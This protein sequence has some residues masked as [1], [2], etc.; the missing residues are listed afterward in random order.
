[1]S[2]RIAVMIEGHIVQ[3]GTPAEVYENPQD[4]RVAEFVGSPE[5]S[6]ARRYPRRRRTRSWDGRWA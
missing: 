6:Y 1:M 2:S 5:I 4:I 3:V